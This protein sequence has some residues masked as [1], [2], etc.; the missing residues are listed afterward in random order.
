MKLWNWAFLL[1]RR[2]I[3]F[4]LFG[5]NRIMPFETRINHLNFHSVSAMINE[6]KKTF[7]HLALAMRTRL[8]LGLPGRFQHWI[9]NVLSAFH[10]SSTNDQTCI[11]MNFREKFRLYKFKC[12]YWNYKKYIFIHNGVSQYLNVQLYCVSFDS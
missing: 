6:F 1:K 10:D 12:Y 3:Y 11:Q 9:I 4:P 5:G 8:R 2:I 7:F